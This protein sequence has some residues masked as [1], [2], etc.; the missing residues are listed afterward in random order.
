MG[1]FG[2]GNRLCCDGS[3]GEYTAVASA[4]RAILGVFSEVVED[5]VDGR[6]GRV[7]IVTVG[8]L[9]SLDVISSPF[10][11]EAD[12]RRWQMPY[13]RRKDEW[14]LSRKRRQATRSGPA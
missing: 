7:V 4:K 9:F 3:I 12:A 6:R 11:H 1:R 14:T 8:P 13:K 10:R 5:S 2:K